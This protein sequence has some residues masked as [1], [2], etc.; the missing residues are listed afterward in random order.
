[1][2][3]QSLL[4]SAILPALAL[5]SVKDRFVSREGS[6]LSLDGEPWR[7]VGANAYWLAMD[8]NVVPAPGKP[9]YKPDMASY[10]TKGRISE[11]MAIIK[12]MG[13][14]MLRVHTLG[15]NSG[16][17]LA[18][19]PDNRVINEEA[20]EY[21]DWTIY[22]ARQ[23]DVRL[24]VPLVDHYVS[25]SPHIKEKASDQGGLLPWR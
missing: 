12:A 19:L 13:G 18:L 24:M 21:I 5:C 10:P 8:E 23:Y 16:N 1:M 14:T 9:F 2:K 4:A 11:A 6:H 15:S 22:Q 17:P 7:P 20:W 3:A 25:H